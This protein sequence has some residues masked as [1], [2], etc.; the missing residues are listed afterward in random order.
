MACVV[1]TCSVLQHAGR[2][3]RGRHVQAGPQ[4]LRQRGQRHHAGAH[5]H[6]RAGPQVSTNTSNE[7]LACN[8]KP[9]QNHRWI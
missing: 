8:T 2:G 7:H 6:A 5:H 1:L 4:L 9:L 3:A